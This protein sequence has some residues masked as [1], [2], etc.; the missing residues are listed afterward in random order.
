[1][2]SIIRLAPG[3]DKNGNSQREFDQNTQETIVRFQA[4]LL[5]EDFLG[6]GH[7]AAFPTA[8][9]TGYPWVAKIVKTAGT[10][11]VGLLASQP[12]GIVALALDATSEAQ[13]AALYSGDQLN[14]DAVKSAQFET[15]MSIATLPSAAAVA[16][17]WGLRSAWSASGPD[18]AATFMDFRLLG[19]G[20]LSVRVK[21]GVT[22][23]ASNIQ[24]Y[25]GANVVLTAGAFHNFRIAMRPTRQTSFSL[26]MAFG[27]ARLRRHPIWCS[28]RDRL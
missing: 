9:T 28:P 21:D 11:T 10:P 4:V 16:M 15:R 17:V 2:G 26:L 14:W 1:M 12:N 27:S 5:D 6:A 24:S 20:A 7:P 3:M 19:S 18:A 8:A 23:G 25:S 22:G 13:E